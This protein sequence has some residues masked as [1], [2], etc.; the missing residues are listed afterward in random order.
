MCASVVYIDKST[1][2]QPEEEKG[3][4]RCQKR[5]CTT[6]DMR[7]RLCVCVCVWIDK[8]VAQKKHVCECT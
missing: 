6:S 1:P 2:E 5:P 4:V 8:C 3:H 7:D